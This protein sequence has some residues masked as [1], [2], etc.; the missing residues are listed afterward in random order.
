[1]ASFAYRPRLSVLIS[2]GSLEAVMSLLRS[3]LLM[4]KNGG[5][6]GNRANRVTG[7]LMLFFSQVHNTL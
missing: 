7:F 5:P 2:F 1:M 6:I 4:R 3:G